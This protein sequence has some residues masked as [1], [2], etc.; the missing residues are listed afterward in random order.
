MITVRVISRSSGK[1][2]K[3][4]KVALE[5]IAFRRCHAWQMDRFS[6]RGALRRK[7]ELRESVCK[8]VHKI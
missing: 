1:P 2:I 7:V 8:W 5:C 4:K 6:W 3:D